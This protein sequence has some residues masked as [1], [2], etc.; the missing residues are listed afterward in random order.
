VRARLED[1]VVNACDGEVFE[2]LVERVRLRELDPHAA[3][4]ALID[5][6]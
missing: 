2:E 4:V 5:H 1:Q 6:G 3:A